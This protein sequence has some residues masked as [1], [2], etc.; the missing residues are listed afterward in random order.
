MDLGPEELIYTGAQ[1]TKGSLVG[2]EGRPGKQAALGEGLWHECRSM[3]SGVL[4][5]GT[6]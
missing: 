5:V 1:S 3:I 4:Y 6:K 2:S